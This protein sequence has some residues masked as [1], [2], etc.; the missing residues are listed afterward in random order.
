M[1]NTPLNALEQSYLRTKATNYASFKDVMKL[2]GNASNN[3][4]YADADG[5]IAYWHGN[6]MP[7]RNPKFD[8]SQPLDGSDT[9]TDWKGLHT[10]DEIVQVKNPTSGWIQNCNSTPFT[11]SGSSSPDKSKYPAYM[12]P[13]AENYR[14]INAARVLSQKSVFT[15]DTLIAAANDPHLAAFDDLIPALLKAWQTVSGESAN[16]SKD[17][18]E[19]MQLLTDWKREY[20]TQSIG[21]T[22]GIVW[23][24]TIQK[25]ARSRVQPGQPLDNLSFMAFT[26]SST[27]PQEK[28]T[29]LADALVSL[30]RDFCSS[31]RTPHSISGRRYRWLV[32]R[33]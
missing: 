1:M 15:L 21:M 33:G 32:N 24:E 31:I 17:L 2:N 20:G 3:T 28:V 10:A 5:T 4:V 19:A 13:D 27:S 7:K 23:G 26:I 9:E 29:A 22:L 6:F 12:A 30:T 18:Q 8:W 25:L 16:Q 11:V 14:G